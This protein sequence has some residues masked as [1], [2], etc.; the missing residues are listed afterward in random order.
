MTKHFKP[1][2]RHQLYLLPSSIDEW[3]PE[4]HLTRLTSHYSNKG[5]QAYD[6]AMIL[7]LLV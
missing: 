6:P 7:S 4:N 1:C 5:S 2:N 3:L